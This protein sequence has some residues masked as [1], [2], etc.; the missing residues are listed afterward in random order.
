MLHLNARVRTIVPFIVFLNFWHWTIYRESVNS[1]V[2]RTLESVKLPSF[3]VICGRLTKIH[4]VKSPIFTAVCMLGGSLRHTNVC[5]ISRVWKAMFSLALDVA[6]S[7]LASL[8]MLRRFYQRCWFIFPIGLS[9][10][11]KKVLKG[12]FSTRYTTYIS[13]KKP[14]KVPLRTRDTIYI[15]DQFF[16]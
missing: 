14:W 10:K 9:Q 1:T 13:N 7:N 11:T 4:S 2:E 8:L 6:L 12:P 15:S 3:R 5:R 16:C